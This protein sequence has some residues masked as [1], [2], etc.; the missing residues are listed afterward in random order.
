[1]PLYDYRCPECGARF[2]QFVRLS[3]AGAPVACPQ[4]GAPKATKQLSTFAVVGGG[5]SSKSVACAPG[6]G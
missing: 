3:E 4:C 5:G 2:E 1:M 6:G